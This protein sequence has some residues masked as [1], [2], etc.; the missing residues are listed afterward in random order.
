M[1]RKFLD[2]SLRSQEAWA[3]KDEW[4]LVGEG[5]DFVNE[6]EARAQTPIVSVV[7]RPAGGGRRKTGDTNVPTLADTVFVASNFHRRGSSQYDFNS[8]NHSSHHSSRYSSSSAH[9]YH[10]PF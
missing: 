6:E 2:L 7:P 1:Y 9:H 4:A 10:P 5:L 8:S 3:L